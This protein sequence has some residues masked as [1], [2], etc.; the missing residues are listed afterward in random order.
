MGLRE[1]L[2]A[3][4]KRMPSGWSFL[5]SRQAQA[6]VKHGAFRVTRTPSQTEFA[7]W[8]RDGTVLYVP[9]GMER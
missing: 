2:P 5:D 7:Q 3:L 8:L 9:S 4:L 6:T 1:I